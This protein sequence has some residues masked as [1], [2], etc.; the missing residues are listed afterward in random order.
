[1]FKKTARKIHTC[2]DC[3][4]FDKSSEKCKHEKM[5]GKQV[6][7]SMETP[8]EIGYFKDKNDYEKG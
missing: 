4:F 6:A 8:C 1:M 5:N 2:G 7:A 3:V